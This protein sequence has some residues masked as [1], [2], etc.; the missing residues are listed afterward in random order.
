MPVEQ[1][2]DTEFDLDAIKKDL[3]DVFDQWLVSY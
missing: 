2:E 1:G 3:F